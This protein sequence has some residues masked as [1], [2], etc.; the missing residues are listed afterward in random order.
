VIGDANFTTRAMLAGYDS[1][2]V[3]G[4]TYA[5]TVEQSG[6]SP[7]GAPHSQPVFIGQ[8]VRD[9]AGQRCARADGDRRAA[10]AYFGRHSTL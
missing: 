9:R 3:N 5:V 7:D 6:G 4:A 8:A 10:R 2:V 1:D